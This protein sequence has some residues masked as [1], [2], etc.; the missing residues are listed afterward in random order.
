MRW[1]Q[2]DEYDADEH[3]DDAIVMWMRSERR[4]GSSQIL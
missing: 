1:E 2:V 3:H 4:S